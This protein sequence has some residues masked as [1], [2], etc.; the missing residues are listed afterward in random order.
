MGN[1]QCEDLTG[2]Q[3]IKASTG[4]GPFQLVASFE[5]TGVD[6]AKDGTLDM[7]V[8]LPFGI[9]NNETMQ[10]QARGDKCM[11]K[12]NCRFDFGE[13]WVARAIYSI[14]RNGFD[15]GPADSLSRLKRA[16]EEINKLQ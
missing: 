3:L 2:G 4:F 11:V 14:F 7:M 16:A 13:G 15:T 9:T 12:Y 10:I 6:R 1:S 5:I 8:K